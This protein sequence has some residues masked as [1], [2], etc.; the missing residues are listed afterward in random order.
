MVIIQVGK[1]TW[2]VKIFLFVYH[3]FVYFYAHS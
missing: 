2:I 1:L 3:Y